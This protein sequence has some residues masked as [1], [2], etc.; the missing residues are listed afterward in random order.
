MTG[1]RSAVTRELV[2]I[3]GRYEAADARA[4]R[5][6]VAGDRDR[7]AAADAEAADIAGAFWD[8][9]DQL[10][11]LCLLLVRKALERNPEA[12]ADLLADAMES[13]LRPIAEAAAGKGGE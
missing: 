6:A 10:S 5:A 4:R 2:A 3:A 7:T 11:E 12:L 13:V 1:I 9:G 8:C